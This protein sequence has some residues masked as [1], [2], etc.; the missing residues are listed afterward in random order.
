MQS[1]QTEIPIPKNEAD[2]ERL[3]A[4][5]YG[6]V[7]E[8]PS[9]KI[10]GRKGQSQGGVDVFINAKDIGRIGI[11]SKKYFKTILTWEHVADEVKKADD[12]KTPIRRLVVAT[13]S[14]SDA[15]LLH[16]VQLLS[17]ERAATGHFTVEVEF[18]DDIENRIRSFN[19]LQD[20]FAPHSPG[21][22]YYRQEQKLSRIEA[23]VTGSNDQLAMI[24]ELP[25]AREDSANKLISA[26]LDGTNTLLKNGRYKDALAHIDSIGKDLGPFDAH[27]KARWHLQRGLSLWFSRDNIKEAAQLFIKA[28]ELYP[29][30][31]RIAAG[32]IRGLLLKEDLEAAIAFGKMAV[33]QFPNSQQVWLALINGRILKGEEVKLD[34]LPAHLR[35]EPDVLQLF[36]IAASKQGRLSEAVRLSQESAAKSGA[37]FFAKAAALQIAVQD[38]GQDP[39]SAMYG[40]LPQTK[41]DVLGASIARFEPRRDALWAVQTIASEEVA[42]HLG[43]ALL[44]RRD[45]AAALDFVKEAQ[46]HG[47]V[48]E[49]ILRIH[50]QALIDLGNGEEAQAVGR[51]NLQAL[52]P[53]S[54]ISVAELAAD[55]GDL[56]FVEEVIALV[57]LKH[58]AQATTLDILTAI[59]WGAITRA[60]GKGAAAEEILQ[61]QLATSESLILIC[62][63][64][65][66]LRSAGK[67][68][69]ASVLVEKARGLVDQD[70]DTSDKLILAELLFSA[71]RWTDA[72]HLYETLTPIGHISELHVRLLTCHVESDNR[73]KARAFLDQL[74]NSWIDN[75][76]IRRLAMDLGQI[77]NDWQ[78][79]S[80]LAEA[81]VQKAPTQATSW[82]FRLHVAR[83]TDTPSAFQDLVRKVPDSLGG[84]VKATAQLAT[85]ELRYGEEE[86]ALRR[87]Y[88]LLRQNFDDPEAF[89]AYFIGIVSGPLSLPCMDAE[90]AAITAGS[91]IVLMGED[92]QELQIVIDPTEVGALPQRNEFLSPDSKEAKALIGGVVG[93]SIEIPSRAFGGKQVY[94]VKSIQSAYRRL[95]HISQERATGVGG[96]PNLKAVTI[97]TS[98][99]GSKDFSGIHAEIRRG[100]QRIQQI[101]DAYDTGGFTLAGVSEM[102]GRSPIEVVL[103]W[104]TDGSAMIVCGGSFAEQEEA[105]G[106]LKK[107]DTEYVIDALTLAEL[108]RFEVSD[109]LGALHKIYISPVTKDIVDE[110]LADVE[111]DRSVGTATEIKGKLSFL[112]IGDQMRQQRIAFARK[113][114]E[115][116]EK[117]CA[118][119]PAYGDLQPLLGVPNFVDVLRREEHEML[120]LATEQKAKLL[121]VDGRFRQLAKLGAHLD[122]VWPQVLVMYC[123]NNNLLDSQRRSEFVIKQL[124]A[125]RRFVSLTENDLIWMV[126]QGGNFLHSGIQAIKPYLERPETDFTSTSQVIVKFLRHATQIPIQFGAFGELLSHFV[127]PLFRRGDCPSSFHSVIAV[128]LWELPEQIA[129]PIH[130]YQPLNVGRSHTIAL[131]RR[132]FQD[133]LEQISDR[134]KKPAEGRAIALNTLFCSK[135]PM[136][137]LD[138]SLS[139]AVPEMTTT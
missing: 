121:S 132:Y 130:G 88:R 98:G 28:A 137:T 126:L 34:N 129:S 82:V 43:Y 64:A 2:F 119:Q 90:V 94:V 63:A 58:S 15:A 20:S 25:T 115:V 3:C 47:V 71:K 70:T 77:A 105:L 69:E 100:S 127:E 59:R 81:Q 79:L 112:E 74:P 89:S 96:I 138:R 26:Q 30:D 125:N 10:N 61:S 102:L 84:T 120:L 54:L 14:P 18:W 85:I 103:G 5:V 136:L 139:P 55:A 45:Y 60:R 87:L 51:A 92:G 46:I 48:P 97:G 19:S 22:A 78:F 106:V 123:A 23:L 17:D 76:Q 66:I 6:V 8:D 91:S 93:Q 41:L 128:L 38:A 124:V 83:H 52:M 27:Q 117:F 110:F 68:I 65:R 37:G 29:N 86:R 111:I 4:Q 11:Q 53:E 16:K 9:P 99:D 113:L 107:S 31:E 67:H 13:T 50:I 56:G 62:A 32:R 133:L 114:V 109:V 39:V 135:I 101:M 57:K 104:P 33:E 131:Q 7:Y 49:G 24:T 12:F 73:K 35:D 40:L 95:L 118:V 44:L 108:V 75:D 21:A 1:L 122:G 36:A 42:V 80:P 116:M 72:A 134:A